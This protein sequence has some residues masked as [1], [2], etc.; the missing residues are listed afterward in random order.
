MTILFGCQFRSRDKQNSRP[1]A[2]CGASRATLDSIVIGQSQGG[3]AVPLR[4]R[5]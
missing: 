5:H 4:L 1:L 3:K 2:R